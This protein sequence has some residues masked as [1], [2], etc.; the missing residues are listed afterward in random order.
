MRI[1]DRRRKKP[2]TLV[3]TSASCL[4]ILMTVGYAAFSTHLDITAKGNV[5]KNPLAGPTDEVITNLVET[6]PDEVYIDDNNNIRYY[7]QDP[8]NYVYFDCTDKNNQTSDTCELWRIMGII[9]GKVKLIRNEALT[10]VT[11]DMQNGVSVTVGTSSGFYWNKVKQEG[12]NYNNWEGSTLQNYLNGTY[13]SDISEDYQTMISPSTFYLGGSTDSNY[14]TL[15]ASGWYDAERD[16]TQVYSGNPVSTKQHIGLMY[17]SDYGYATSGG[18]T[19]DKNS[20]LNK[21]LYNWDS[22]SYSDCKNNDYLFSG[23]NEWLQAPNAGSSNLAAYL[24]STGYVNYASAVGNYSRAV[25]PV[26]YL[27]SQTQI[28]TGKGTID[29]PFELG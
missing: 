2:L 6:N 21:K 13:Y 25:R 24:N 14:E 1:R 4:L 8:N 27:T 17:P 12:K 26:L 5:V 23:K 11:T 7:G 20:C 10:P 3:I 18:S 29:E 22:S 28:V 16:G 15:T 9:D 19:T